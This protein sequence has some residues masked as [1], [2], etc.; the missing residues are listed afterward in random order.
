MNLSSLSNRWPG[1]LRQLMKKE[2][3]ACR[4]VLGQDCA[5]CGA[6]DGDRLVCRHCEAALVRTPHACRRCAL[7]LAPPADQCGQCLRRPPPFDAST[8]AFAYT[9]P[10]DRLLH[11]FKFTGDLA[12]GRW[13]ALSLLE[14]VRP[15][16]APDLIVPTPLSRTR[17][18]ERGFNQ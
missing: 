13:L 6:R 3:G 9:F 11:R 18:R 15:Q 7:P 17:L 2:A 14:A 5:L 8:A 1:S 10:T 4:T 16:R 12:V